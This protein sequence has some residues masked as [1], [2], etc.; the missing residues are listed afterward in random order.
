VLGFWRCRRLMG[1]PNGGLFHGGLWK[2]GLVCWWKGSVR[3][4]AGGAFR[5]VEGFR[6]PGW[7]GLFLGGKV[8][9]ASDSGASFVQRKGSVRS[10]SFHP[11]SRIDGERV[12]GAPRRAPDTPGSR[13]TKSPLR[14]SLASISSLQVGRDTASCLSR[15]HPRIPAGMTWLVN[16]GSA[17]LMPDPPPTFNFL[18]FTGLSLS[19]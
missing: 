13:P 18:C 8:R 16:S 3:Q 5:A 11:W 9:V 6:S 17:I 2:R 4:A 12:R 7:R 15:P 19:L 1:P 10:Y 14:G